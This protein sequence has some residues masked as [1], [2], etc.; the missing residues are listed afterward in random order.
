MKLLFA[1]KFPENYIQELKDMGHEVTYKPELTAENLSEYVGNNEVIIV[2][3]TKVTEPTI[4]AGK[5]LSL[6]IRAGAGT[7]TID[8]KSAAKRGIFVCN[9]PGKN[10]IAVAEVAFGLLLNIDRKIADNVTELKQK[11]WNKKYFSKTRGIYGRNVGIIG[12]GQIG[13]NFAVRAHA[14]GMNI[15]IDEETKAWT[16]PE[17]LRDLE[18]LNCTILPTRQALAEKCDVITIHVPATP[19]TKGMINS[20]FLANMQNDAILLNT[21]RGNV[22]VDEDLIAAMNTKNI[23]CG[24]DVFNNEPAFGEGVWSSE[25][26]LHPN[27]YGTHHIGASTEQAQLAIA[28]KVIDVIKDFEKGLIDHWVNLETALQAT[29][30]LS[31]RHND[32]VGVLANVLDILKKNNINIEQIENKNFSGKIAAFTNI[33]TESPIT[34]DAIAEIEK[35]EDIIQVSYQQ[36]ACTEELVL[37]GA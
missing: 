14:F 37:A 28:A 13:Y 22:V 20:E 31:I 27:V 4:N 26:S 25:L 1:D 6:I 32:K 11:K 9:T 7:N 17:T 8:V 16:T 24:L 18:K 12:M 23:K 35:L 30:A 34:K 15:F 10:A 21:S 29:P 33:Y 3:S 36:I 5:N 19:A 2:R